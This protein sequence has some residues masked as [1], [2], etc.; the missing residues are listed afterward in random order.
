MNKI[1]AW[2]LGM[3]KVGKQIK[4]VQEW[5]DGKKQIIASLAAAIPAT[6]LI[7]QKFTEQGTTYLVSVASTPEFLAASG[8]WV[9]LFNGLKGEKIRAENAEIITKLDANTAITQQV[10]DKQ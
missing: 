6:I 5:L 10:A 8:G 4:R 3:T 9:A 7:I 2:I 1:Y